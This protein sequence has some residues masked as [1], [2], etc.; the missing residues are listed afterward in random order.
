[1]NVAL[2]ASS[3]QLERTP[4]D[5][6]A[7]PPGSVNGSVAGTALAS[8]I[9]NGSVARAVGAAR[10]LDASERR[11]VVDQAALARL[12]AGR[13]AGVGR[14][15][16]CG[17][18]GYARAGE[19]V[20][21][22]SRAG[23]QRLD[24]ETNRT[25][26]RCACGSAAT[27]GGPCETCRGRRAAALGAEALSEAVTARAAQA[28]A[29]AAAARVARSPAVLLAPQRTAGSRMLAR[30]TVTTVQV[31]P[32]GCSL[33]QHRDIEPAVTTASDWLRRSIALLDAYIAAPTADATKATRSA[34]RRNFRSTAVAD[35]TH[36]RDRFSTILNDMLTSTTLRTEC[37]TNADSTCGAANAYVRGSLFVFCPVF[38]SFSPLARAASVI[39][40][41]AHALTGTPHITD[42]AYRSNRYYRW[43]TPAE[44]RTNAESYGM[45]A[46]EL[47]TGKPVRDTA[48]HDTIE[49]C[50]DDWDVALA[51][52]TAIA[53]RW[54]RNA[55]TLL[56]DRRPGRL[57]RWRVSRRSISARRPPLHSTARS[58]ST[59]RRKTRSGRRLTSSAS[60]VRP[61]VAAR[62]LRRTGMAGGRT[63]TSAPA[64]GRSQLSPIAPSRSS[65]ASTATGTSSTTARGARTSPRSRGR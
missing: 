55:H 53:E 12:A 45:L 11:S 37:H 3:R 21:Y 44:A 15:V 58:G 31:A 20:S 9:G 59:T 52:S 5:A 43:M 60:P 6:V 36:V 4:A 64:G 24:A 42:R 14:P 18:D 28:G 27:G 46:R 47:G 34:M 7:P 2:D 32:G 16:R 19:F 63:S 51:R 62:A 23:D 54:N 30:E 26:S 17:C 48:A 25:L 40:E 29:T 56:R 39:H 65:S 8:M 10:T 41:M 13:S 35:A 49:D 61:E 22:R 57:A 50:P 33:A 38:F 1:M